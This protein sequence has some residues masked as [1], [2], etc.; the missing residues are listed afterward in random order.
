M[1]IDVGE[2]AAFLQE[3]GHD[4]AQFGGEEPA[5]GEVKVAPSGDLEAEQ[6]VKE[7][8][9]KPDAEA[10]PE[11]A[12]LAEAAEAEAEGD[13]EELEA[14][15]EQGEEGDQPEAPKPGRW[16]RMKTRAQEAEQRVQYLEGAQNEL[17]DHADYFYKAAVDARE[18]LAYAQAEIERLRSALSEYDLPTEPGPEYQAAIAAQREAAS[19]RRQ[20]E[21][22]QLQ[23]KA[24]RDAQIEQ[25][26]LQAK[27]LIDAESRS[28]GLDPVKLT[29]A[30]VAAKQYEPNLTI[31]E[32]AARVAQASGL[33]KRAS[34]ARS[35]V[36]RSQKSPKP[37]KPGS[38]AAANYDSPT[39][40]NAAAYL[41]SIGEL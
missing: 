8:L 5:D 15:A 11:G 12:E 31:P 23:Q 38:S 29:K 34:A 27:A 7:A 9:A 37:L 21:Q 16:Q 18:E 6:A 20:L 26:A 40:E 3:Q 25:R 22:I 33:S 28:Y 41:K 24:Q 32:V 10:E 36:A 14:E 4:L 19:A 35:Q 17:V 39:V 2:A 30:F 13:E 1:P